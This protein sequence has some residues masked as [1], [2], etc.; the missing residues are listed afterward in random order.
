MQLLAAPAAFRQAVDLGKLATAGG[1]SSGIDLALHVVERYFGRTVASDAAYH[2][3][4]QGQGWLDPNS[5]RAY[6]QARVST[7]EHP[8][9]PVCEMDVDKVTAPRSS[10]EGQTFYFCSEAHKSL[11]DS[12]PTRFIRA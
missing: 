12:S 5:N 8:L 10:Y 1:L 3:E 9:C 7:D 2:M 4:Y 11:F 6:A